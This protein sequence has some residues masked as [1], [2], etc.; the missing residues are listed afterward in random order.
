MKERIAPHSCALL[1]H[2]GP[3]PECAAL[4]PPKNCYC[5]KSV[6][7][8]FYRLFSYFLLGTKNVVGWLMK[9]KVAEKR[10]INLFPVDST[11][12]N[13]CVMLGLVN[14]VPF[15][16]H[17]SATVEKRP[18]Q[19]HV[20]QNPLQTAKIVP[21]GKQI[22]DITHVEKRVEN[23]YLVEFITVPIFVTN[24][25]QTNPLSAL[26]VPYSHRN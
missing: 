15:K 9:E 1:C 23:C 19:K 2:P 20:A 18:L 17:K 5:G 10:A 6:Y 14:P 12:A 7:G 13:K 25:L 26:H 11:H 22:L 8:F 21:M 3:C 16:F 4:A 24:L